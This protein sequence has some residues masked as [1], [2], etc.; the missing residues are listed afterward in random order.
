MPAPPASSVTVTVGQRAQVKKC[1][2]NVHAKSRLTLEPLRALRSE[3]KG[4]AGACPDR[5]RAI[6]CKVRIARILSAAA[7]R[8]KIT[9][10]H[11]LPGSRLTAAAAVTGY[12]QPPASAHNSR[13]IGANL[14]YVRPES[15]QSF[16]GT[17]PPRTWPTRFGA[18]PEVSW[19]N[20]QPT[21]PRNRLPLQ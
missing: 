4:Q 17:A 19:P 9:P 10:S 16:D 5:T 2:V 11:P 18:R 1:L 15:G 14:R 3:D 21:R 20:R 13:T 6:P 8:G 12:H 7:L